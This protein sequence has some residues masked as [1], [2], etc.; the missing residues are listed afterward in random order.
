MPRR[1]KD[2]PHLQKFSQLME[3]WGRIHTYASSLCTVYPQTTTM[4]P[5]SVCS[6][7]HQVSGRLW[8]FIPKSDLCM[9]HPHPWFVLN[10]HLWFLIHCD[11]EDPSFRATPS[12]NCGEIENIDNDFKSYNVP[13]SYAIKAAKDVAGRVCFGQHRQC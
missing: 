13:C 8:G 11:S 6:D 5:R 9:V 2:M 7:L 4:G 3:S 10:I 12:T 1:A